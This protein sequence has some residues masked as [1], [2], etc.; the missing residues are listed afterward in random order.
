MSL[1]GT[2]NTTVV[3]S[4]G[5]GSPQYQI[6]FLFLFLILRLICLALLTIWNGQM[7]KQY[8]GDFRWIWNC[9]NEDRSLPSE[10]ALNLTWWLL[11]FSIFVDGE[12]ICELIFLNDYANEHLEKI[13]RWFL[14]L[15][16]FHAVTIVFIGYIIIS[17]YKPYIETIMDIVSHHGA[18][19][20]LLLDNESYLLFPSLIISLFYGIH[21]FC[22]PL[23]MQID[24]F[25]LMV[26]IILWIVFNGIS[27]IFFILKITKKVCFYCKIYS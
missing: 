24:Q 18:Y 19:S 26:S 22:V 4:P 7:M 25:L 3:P 10:K 17:W 8:Y 14:L 20:D 6:Y 2:S 21:I 1:R 9:S 27:F 12:T 13:T 11:C 15:N 5:K 16:L 23:I